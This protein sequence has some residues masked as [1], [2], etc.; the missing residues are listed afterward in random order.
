MSRFRR[1]R[2]ALTITGVWSVVW[3]VVGLTM[4]VLFGYG[5]ELSTSPAAEVTRILT[6][7]LLIWALVGAIN[8]LT[9][10]VVLATL[11]RRWRRPLTGLSV[12]LFGAISGSIPP[13]ILMSILTQTIRNG[14][15]PVFVEALAFTAVW[16]SLGGFLGLA[17]FGAARHE[18]LQ[19]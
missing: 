18:A 19:H 17:T 12:A 4:S 13:L 14:G 15:L 2:A 7:A 5:H 10:S 1:A 9:F 11:G 6:I 16:A 3:A 8:G